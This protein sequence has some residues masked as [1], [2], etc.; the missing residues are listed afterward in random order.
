MNLEIVIRRH[1]LVSHHQAWKGNVL[2]RYVFVEMVP[3]IL[4]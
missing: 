1:G 2:R 3:Q 4:P